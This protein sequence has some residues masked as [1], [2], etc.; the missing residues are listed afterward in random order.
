[1][2]IEYAVKRILRKHGKIDF[3]SRLNPDS[4][5]MDAGCG[6]NSPFITKQILPDC[7]YT[8]LDVGD[9]NQTKPL[10]ADRYIVTTAEEF[11][12]EI[13]R[14]PE[15]FDAVISNHNLEHCDDRKA[16]LEAMLNALKVGGKL[17]LSFPCEQSVS[18]P[19]R[20]GTLNYY[21]DPTHKFSPPNFQETLGAIEKRGFEIEYSEKNYS[22]KML[23]FVGWVVEMFSRARNKCMTGTWAYYGFESIII[24]RKIKQVPSGGG[25]PPPAS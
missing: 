22:P 24:A 18:F 3:L 19:R 9:Y 12:A 8:G 17:F 1:M 15:A 5:I 16:T 11:P 6:N 21:D 23:R 20:G 25:A 2:K 10:S 13:A 7:H 14:F 4:S